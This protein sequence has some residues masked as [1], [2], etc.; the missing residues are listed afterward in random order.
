MHVLP[1]LQ[2][3][4]CDRENK[5]RNI[6]KGK[7]YL[8]IKVGTQW[9]RCRWAAHMAGEVKRDQLQ[10]VSGLCHQEGIGQGNTPKEG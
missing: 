2:P 4:W 6:G 3:F 8:C 7:N 5:Q 1:L 10:L 9:R